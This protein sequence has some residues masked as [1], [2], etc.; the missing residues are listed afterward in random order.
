MNFQAKATVGF[1]LLAIAIVVSL[2]LLSALV[3]MWLVNVVLGQYS[4]ELLNY[5]SALAVTGLLWI[6]GG[7]LGINNGKS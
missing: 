5:G 4:A 7:L 6:F 2:F 3:L 1:V